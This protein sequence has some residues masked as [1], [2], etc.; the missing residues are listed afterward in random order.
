[1][2]EVSP[3]VV[4]HILRMHGAPVTAAG[5]DSGAAAASARGADDDASGSTWSLDPQKVSAFRC[6]QLLEE[7]KAA[8]QVGYR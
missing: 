5:G 1:M 6:R 3:T 7:K 2:P 4:L 8:G